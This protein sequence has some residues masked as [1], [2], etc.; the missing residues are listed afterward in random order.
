[1]RCGHGL[2][3]PDH[4]RVRY[5]ASRFRDALR[6]SGP[7]DA[8]APIGLQLRTSEGKDRFNI[9]TITDDLPQIGFREMTRLDTADDLFKQDCSSVESDLGA[10]RRDDPGFA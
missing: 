7:S 3:L 9:T 4:V 10:V 8:T 2:L 5:A 1:M 6:L